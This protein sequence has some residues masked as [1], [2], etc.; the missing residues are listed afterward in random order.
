[1]LAAQRRAPERAFYFCNATTIDQHGARTF[2]FPDQVKTWIQPSA[3]KGLELKGDEGLA[4]LL[5][6][7]FIMC[8]TICYQKSKI[9]GFEFNES[10]KQ[11]LDL[12][13]YSR[14][15]FAGMTLAGVPDTCYLYRRHEDNQTSRLT[16]DL[17]RF[18]EEIKLYRQIS[19]DAA[20]LGW[21]KSVLVA[22]QQ[23]M[24]KLNLMYCIVSDIGKGQL[25]SSWQKLKFLAKMQLSPL[26]SDRKEH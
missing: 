11:V 8:P 17:T 21:K 5:R 4:A 13:F 19:R 3:P 6:G 15:L 20:E 18:D 24:I 16:L 23:T 9:V 2:S 12:E 26:K 10:R 1:M 22:K 25:R 14:L 7:C